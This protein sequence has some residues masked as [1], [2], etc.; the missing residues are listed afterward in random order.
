MSYFIGAG[1]PS[2]PSSPLSTDYVAN[3][4]TENEVD[5]GGKFR[6]HR[7]KCGSI[8]TSGYELVV[9]ILS[10][11]QTSRVVYAVEE[12]IVIIITGT[13]IFISQILRMVNMFE[14]VSAFRACVENFSVQLPYSQL[15]LFT[16]LNDFLRVL[17][18]SIDQLTGFNFLY[19]TIAKMVAECEIGTTSTVTNEQFPSKP[20]VRP[21]LPH[22]VIILLQ[23]HRIIYLMALLASSEHLFIDF[24]L[25]FLTCVFI[26]RFCAKHVSAT[27]GK[28]L[29][30]ATC[31]CW[32]L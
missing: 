31:V 10:L 12:V 29:R 11:P 1:I 27:S 2:P 23:G 17:I 21:A 7:P 19:K 30:A 22:Q 26:K 28:H 8:E 20:L 16:S 25:S 4:N 9:Q 24:I 13:L 3:S 6:K 32:S 14:T 18:S 5:N 15:E